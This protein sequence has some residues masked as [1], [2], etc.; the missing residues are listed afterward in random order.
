MEEVIR[1]E[2]PQLYA[3]ITNNVNRIPDFDKT[4]TVATRWTNVSHSSSVWSSVYRELSN[5]V[6]WTDVFAIINGSGRA[7]DIPTGRLCEFIQKFPTVLWVGLM[8]MVPDKDEPFRVIVAA[9]RLD[10]LDDGLGLLREE[11]G[12]DDNS[13]DAMRRQLR[14][15]KLTRLI[16]SEIS[17][18]NVAAEI[19]SMYNEEMSAIKK[20]YTKSILT[21]E[22]RRTPTIRWGILRVVMHS[23]WYLVDFTPGNWLHILTAHEKGVRVPEDIIERLIQ[24]ASL[25]VRDLPTLLVDFLIRYSYPKQLATLLSHNDS[26]DN[27]LKQLHHVA[28]APIAQIIINKARNIKYVAISLI[29]TNI[30]TLEDDALD[31][32]TALVEV[33]SIIYEIYSIASN[34]SDRFE[35]IRK[36]LNIAKVRDA[37]A[38]NDIGGVYCYYSQVFQ[39][40][41]ASGYRR[42]S[43]NIIEVIRAMIS[44]LTVINDMA[45]IETIINTLYTNDDYT[46]ALLRDILAI[47]V[48]NNP[49]NRRIANTLFDEASRQNDKPLSVLLAKTSLI[50][51]KKVKKLKTTLDR[52]S[53]DYKDLARICAKSTT[54]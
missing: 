45:M 39:S 5:S 44:P 25:E 30:T 46:A 12:L 34:C 7:S 52:H 41:F 21:K 27:Y 35:D 36:L 50:D 9:N 26:D 3:V 29:R 49:E 16:M 38:I 47:P 28:T 54:Q 37:I 11:F 48:V 22:V 23:I 6:N 24:L 1:D 17:S 51:A 42:V 13:L 10:F 18:S 20:T 4:F 8:T 31:L 33:N 19:V 2:N 43:T 32:L 53:H 40:L 14:P 15:A